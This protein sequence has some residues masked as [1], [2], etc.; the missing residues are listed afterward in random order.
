MRY[1]TG[2]LIQ[3]GKKAE[4]PTRLQTGDDENKKVVNKENDRLDLFGAC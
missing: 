4:Q 3:E 1:V 2:E